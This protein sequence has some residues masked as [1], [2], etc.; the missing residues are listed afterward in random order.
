MTTFLS[1]ASLNVGALT[2]DDIADTAVWIN[3][4]DLFGMSRVH[5][6]IHTEEERWSK[7]TQ[8]CNFSVNKCLL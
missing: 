8:R 4:A 7:N 1:A 5:L 6:H 3:T 2:S